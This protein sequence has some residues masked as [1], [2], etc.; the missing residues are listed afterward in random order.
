MKL[1]ETFIK[2]KAGEH[3][4]EDGYVVSPDFVAVV[5]GVTSKSDFLYEGKTTGKLAEELVCA[6]VSKLPREATLEQ[7]L[8]AFN[9]EINAF[10]ERVPFPYDRSELGLQAVCAL[11]S[12]HFREVWLIGDCQAM[13]D[14]T[15]YVNAKRSD[16]VLS[17]MRS[18]VLS[19]LLRGE[20]GSPPSETPQKTARAVIEP[21]ILRANCFANSEGSEYSYAVLNGQPLP[22][23]LVCIIPL[24]GGPHEIVLATDG[25][26]ELRRDLRASEERLRQVIDDDPACYRLYR[27]TKGVAKSN[28][29]F[30]DRT[31]IRFLI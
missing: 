16:E 21:W 23:S 20:S 5:D 15:P 27:S 31:Y 22:L 29:S 13:V 1:I 28:C 18:L 25:Y 14:G 10:Y 17:E 12:D 7:A 26:P 2:G 11:Y 8:N 6:A 24:D 9:R 30:D 4:C 19:I 3:K